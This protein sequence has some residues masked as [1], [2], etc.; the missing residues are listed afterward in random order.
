MPNLK[1]LVT[2]V[3]VLGP[4]LNL[5]LGAAPAAQA[6]SPEAWQELYAKAQAACIKATPL[7]G[8]KVRSETADFPGAVLLIVDGNHPNGSRGVSY[9]LY[10]K[11]TAKTE[12]TEAQL[13]YGA[14]VPKPTPATGRTC[15]TK[16]FAAQLKTPRPIGTPCIA[17]NDEGDDYT[18][19]VR[20]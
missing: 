19:V 7:S 14:A 8:A 16:S 10:D 2:T 1:Q 6:S 11:V 18:G 20:R 3:L 12:T 9:C 15:W 4:V 17:K 5:V 13:T